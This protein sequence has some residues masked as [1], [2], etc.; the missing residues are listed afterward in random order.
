M[1]RF[2][3]AVR[4]EAAAM[5]HLNPERRELVPTGAGAACGRLA[6][7]PGYDQARFNE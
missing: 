6:S 4:Q 7:R 3:K 1:S 5:R 2:T